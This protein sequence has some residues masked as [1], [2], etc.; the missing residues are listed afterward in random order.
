MTKSA[1]FKDFNFKL[2]AI[3]ELMY[4]QEILKP[5]FN[6]CEF[7]ENY[8]VRQIDIEREGYEIIPEVRQYFE[9]LQIPL[10]LL[11]GIEEIYQDGG[12]EI[13][14][15]ICPLWDGEDDRFDIHSADDVRSLP[16]LK[17]ITLIYN[18]D[19]DFLEQFEKIG[20]KAKWL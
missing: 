5:R 6:I 2:A 17:F 12:N 7:I 4:E 13:Y 20:I 3:N 14:M 11:A 18:G 1:E 16:N 10:D 9:S 19:R 8:S 15:Q